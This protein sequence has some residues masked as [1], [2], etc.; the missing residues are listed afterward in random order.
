VLAAVLFLGE[1]LTYINCT[2]LVVLVLGVALFNYT[3]YK[4]VITGQ[5]VSTRAP[6]DYEKG[7]LRVERHEAHNS[8]RA[9]LVGGRRINLGRVLVPYYQYVGHSVHTRACPSCA[10]LQRGSGE[11]KGTRPT[12]VRSPCSGWRNPCSIK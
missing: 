10:F 11:Q 2:G 5:A 12:V 9:L 6:V 3:K 8:E 1:H 7:D 4:K